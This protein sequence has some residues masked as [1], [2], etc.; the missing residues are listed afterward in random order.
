MENAF[1]VRKGRAVGR[2]CP[3]LTE[4]QMSGPPS[5]VEKEA[6]VSPAEAAGGNSGDRRGGQEP[7]PHMDTDLLLLLMLGHRCP[8]PPKPLTDRADVE[9][10]STAGREMGDRGN[11]S[12]RPHAG[13]TAPL[14]D[15]Y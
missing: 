5:D 9:P 4:G 6:H 3:S 2:N 10:I 12:T 14:D 15:K 7:P 8:P 13:V 1:G 11:P